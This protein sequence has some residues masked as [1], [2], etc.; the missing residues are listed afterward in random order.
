MHLPKSYHIGSHFQKQ[1]V[2][3]DFK[4]THTKPSWSIFD[5]KMDADVAISKVLKDLN[6]ELELKQEQSSINWKQL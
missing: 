2:S 1:I 4:T 5:L 3:H 6:I